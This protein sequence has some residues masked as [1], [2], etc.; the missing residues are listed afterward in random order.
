MAA[1]KKLLA[2]LGTSALGDL[3]ADLGDDEVKRLY[4]RLLTRL[5]E[6]RAMGSK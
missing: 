3:V 5:M 6:L 4:A 1:A 2:Y